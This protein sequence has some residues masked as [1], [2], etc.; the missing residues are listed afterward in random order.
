M[1]RIRYNW[2]EISEERT[3]KRRSAKHLE[4]LPSLLE[5]A[6]CKNLSTASGVAYEGTRH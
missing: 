5:G 1:Q 3:C 6:R 2:G 4:V